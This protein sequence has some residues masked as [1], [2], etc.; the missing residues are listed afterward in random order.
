MVMI[1]D[2]NTVI[3]GS[4][5]FIQATEGKNAERESSGRETERNAAGSECESWGVVGFA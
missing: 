5:N 2:G 1:I 4:F 3:T